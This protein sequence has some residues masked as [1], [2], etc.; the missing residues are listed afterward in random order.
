MCRC[1]SLKTKKFSYDR[2]YFVSVNCVSIL[3]ICYL[4][5]VNTLPGEATLSKLFQIPFEKG[6]GANAFLIE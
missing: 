5:G 2:K 4:K 6:L 3:L 1:A